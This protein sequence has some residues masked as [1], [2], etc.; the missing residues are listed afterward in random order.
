MRHPKSVT[1]LK[2]NQTGLVSFLVV[3]VIMA[4]LTLIVVAYAQIT[5][6]EQRQALDR[7]L[8][9]QAF[10]AA[11]SGVNDV[12]RTLKNAIEVSDT[13]LLD[14]DYTNC[15]GDTSFMNAAGLDDESTISDE[16]PINYSCL[17][18]DASP[19][20]LSYDNITVGNSQVIPIRAKTGARVRTLSFAWR[21]RGQENSADKTGCP[22]QRDVE[23]GVFV[24]KSTPDKCE[25]P[26]LRIEL[27]PFED[28]PTRSQL[29]ENRAI[30]FVQ[31][32][33]DDGPTETSVISHSF[34]QASS[35]SV[36]NG[37]GRIVPAWCTKSDA[38]PFLSNCT[39]SITNLPG[40]FTGYVRVTP[41]YYPAQ[42]WVT[43]S[44]G[45]DQVEFTG[46][47][48]EIDA[49]GRANDV[50]KR[51]LVH[52]SLGENTNSP[53]PSYALQSTKTQCK[54]FSLSGAT[55]TIGASATGDD[56]H[57][58]CDPTAE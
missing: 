40:R 48:V 7:Q 1:R 9:S 2:S 55:V 52:R 13:T 18:V 3:I 20:R 33:L 6:R 42:L 29:I 49:T 54:L 10:Y 11:E 14:N 26:V 22:S 39:V 41:L 43:G 35:L 50:V 25:H 12:M 21:N 16:G 31:P 34:S 37:Q 51:I 57:N 23:D 56:L 45:S 24:F 27:I 47:Q 44:S 28:N 53:L 8:N 4:I 36:P 32:V 58:L 19:K 46:A 5:R 15:D 38:A 30:F 17:L